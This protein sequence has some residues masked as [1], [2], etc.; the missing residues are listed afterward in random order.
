MKRARSAR[1][2][3]GK[4]NI[5]LVYPNTYF[6]GMSNLGLH[7]M[8]RVL[9]A[10]PPS[11]A[12]AFSPDFERSVESSRSLQDFHVIAF[13]VSYELDWI[14]MLRIMLKEQYPAPGEGPPGTGPSSWQEGPLRPSTRSP[15][16]MPRPVLPWRRG[17]PCV[18]PLR[19]L[20]S[21]HRPRGFLDRLQGVQGIYIPE[22][23]YPVY[24]EERIP[25][26]RRGTGP[27]S[28]L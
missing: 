17:A 6:V 15:W 12:N 4:L 5:A 22:R 14:N 1:I 25:G 19:C 16:P 20:F 18:R 21:E 3:G 9:N 27:A 13:S 2:P 8:Y 23:T 24:E 11:C 28:P 7:T 10:I 26:I